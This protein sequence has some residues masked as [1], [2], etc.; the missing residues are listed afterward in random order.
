VVPAE[1]LAPVGGALAETTVVENVV[2]GGD[3]AG[4]HWFRLGEEEMGGVG[5]SDWRRNE[6]NRIFPEWETK[7]G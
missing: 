5:K 1:K 2:A 4:T 3:D 7:S 6:G